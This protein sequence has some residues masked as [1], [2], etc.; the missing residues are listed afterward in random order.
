MHKNDLS[1]RDLAFLEILSGKAETAS[2]GE[3]TETDWAALADFAM[4]KNLA[5]LF[6]YRLG[7]CGVEN[8]IPDPVRQRLH[9]RYL[10]QAGLT[11]I[12]YQQ[13]SS[14]LGA[15]RDRALP[16]IVLKGAHLARHVYDSPALRVMADID[17]LA[18]IEDLAAAAETAVTLGYQPKRNV[19]FASPDPAWK[20]L[21]RMTKP[22][23]FPLE[24]HLNISHPETGLNVPSVELWDRAVEAD[25]GGVSARTLAAEDLLLHLCL[26][27]V[28][29]HAFEAGLR[30]LC[31]IDQTVRRFG[32][33]LD[34]P[35]LAERAMRWKIRSAVWVAL[36][37]TASLLETP[38]PETLL[39]SLRPTRLDEES[40]NWLRGRLF[41]ASAG[42]NAPGFA[43][44]LRRPGLKGK[45][46][47]LANR[48]FPSRREMAGAYPAAKSS[49]R[50]IFYY[51]VRWV[52]LLGR[53]LPVLW[54]TMRGDKNAGIQA[55]NQARRARLRK[56]LQES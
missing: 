46:R 52:E 33:T 56:W 39:A 51:P 47:I 17:L 7:K 8:G 45:I 18:R 41:T 14:L 19:S 34:W 28:P 16:V 40:L 15:L 12:Y 37:A 1:R 20:H 11:T 2:L 31:D 32:R 6:Y 10:T 13:L 36:D 53:Y 50:L 25:Y 27:A 23:A 30:D 43:E 38:I 5:P 35:A 24:I 3:L 9:A 48:L 29:H 4:L 21:P 49:A 22:D 54:R 55:E 44:L 26:H 42:F